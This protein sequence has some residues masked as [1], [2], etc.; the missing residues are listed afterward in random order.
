MKYYNYFKI[1][2]K[3]FIVTVTNLKSIFLVYDGRFLNFGNMRGGLVYD[4]VYLIFKNLQKL[5]IFFL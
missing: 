3:K 2:K 1:F 5:F 4:F